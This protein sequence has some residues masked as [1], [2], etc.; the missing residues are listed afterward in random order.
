MGFNK[1]DFRVES[2]KM[3][4][5]FRFL[6]IAAAFASAGCSPSPERVASSSYVKASLKVSEAVKAFNSADYA[7]ALKFFG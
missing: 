3:E 1:I 7:C 5:M 2:D 4:L 6:L